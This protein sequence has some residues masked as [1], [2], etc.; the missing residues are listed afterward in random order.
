M[1]RQLA[2]RRQRER[3]VGVLVVCLGIVVLVVALLALREPGGHVAA[4]QGSGSPSNVAKHSQSPTTRT[5]PKPHT[6]A[7]SSQKTNKPGVPLIVLNVTATS[8]LAEQAAQRFEAGGWTVTMWGTYQNNIA[9]TCAYYD[10][11]T[12]GAKAAAEALQAQF[13]TIKRVEPRFAPDPDAQPLPSGPV[14]VVLT[15]DYSAA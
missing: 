8:G 2:R 9:S 6:S 4:A 5:N 13:P 11:A 1:G 15:S 7:S 12:A 3:A 10:P 14:V